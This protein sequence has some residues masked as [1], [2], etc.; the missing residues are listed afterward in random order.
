MTSDNDEDTYRERPG[1]PVPD[2][3][4]D[5]IDA[6]CGICDYKDDRTKCPTW[7][8]NRYVD[9]NWCGWSVIGEYSDVGNLTRDTVQIGSVVYDRQNVA[10]IRVA[11]ETAKV[12]L[13]KAIELAK[14]EEL[15]RPKSLVSRLR[16]ALKR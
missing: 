8:Q 14:A 15:A 1:R 2:V 6:F 16:S 9:S 11:V 13:A 10:E 5:A 4:Q 7:D 12:E 3:P